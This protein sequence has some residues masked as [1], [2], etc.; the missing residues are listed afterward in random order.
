MAKEEKKREQNTGEVPQEKKRGGFLRRLM[1]L[2]LILAVVLAVVVLTAMKDGN[3]FSALRR[4][5]VY[6]DSSQT[7]NYYSYSADPENLYGQLEGNLLVVSSN[8]IRLLQDNGVTLYDLP[9][10]LESPMLTVGTEQ[11][12]VCDVGGSAVYVLDSVGINRTLTAEHGLCYYTARMNSKDYLAVTEQKNGY[13]ASVSVYDD[14]GELIFRFDS[15]DSYL[16]DAAVTEDGKYL[17]AVSLAP[18]EGTFTSTLLYY[19]INSGELLG[20]VPIR[21]GLVLDFTDNGD[22]AVA[23]CDKRLSLTNRA[24]ETLL[25]HEFGNLYLHDYALTGGSFCALLLGRYQA[26]N[27][28]ELTTFAMDGT[29]IA[30]KEVTEEILAL[31]AKGDYLAVLYSDSLVIYTRDLTEYARLDDTGYAGQVRMQADGTALVI[32]GSSAWRFVP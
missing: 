14:E 32:G 2:F 9:V 13:K 5:L 20:E 1:T 12:V 17:M 21:D 31:S 7:Q 15:Y 8:A 24:G 28:C 6:G 27:I 22:V 30:A 4:W 23:L 10:S 29:V 16:S 11:A 18:L 3:Y 26:G 25:D 19:D